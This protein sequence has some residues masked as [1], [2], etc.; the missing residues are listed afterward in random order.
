MLS[1]SPNYQGNGRRGVLYYLEKVANSRDDYYVGRGEAL[2]VWLGHGAAALDLSG[3]VDTDDYLAVM[4]GRSP[5]DCRQLVERQGERQVC[6]WCLTFSAPKS[7]SLLWAF[8]GHRVADA[9]CAAHDCPGL[10]N[11]RSGARLVD[12]ELGDLRVGS[13]V[14]RVA[15]AVDFS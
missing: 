11:R 2:G 3:T 7:L 10:L 12:G 14:I 8:G 1:I 5:I 13:S 4:E 15:C 9:L 6:G